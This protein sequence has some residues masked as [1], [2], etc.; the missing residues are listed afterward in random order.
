MYDTVVLELVRSGRVQ[1]AVCPLRWC[2]SSRCLSPAWVTGGFDTSPSSEIRTAPCKRSAVS[3]RPRWSSPRSPLGLRVETRPP[4]P[5]DPSDAPADAP[6]AEIAQEAR[7][8]AMQAVVVG[9]ASPIHLSLTR[10]CLPPACH[11]A[12]ESLDAQSINQ[13]CSASLSLP[14]SS[15][16][17][18]LPSRPPRRCSASRV[19]RLLPRRSRSRRCRASRRAPSSCPATASTRCSTRVRLLWS[20]EPSTVASFSTE[21]AIRWRGGQS[22]AGGVVRRVPHI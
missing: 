11:L 20:F 10:L 9:G 12:L 1:P 2:A 4:S 6:A 14:A 21:A 3:S 13:S 15:P 18:R 8:L 5:L 17:S 16:P 22:A 19:S 7:I